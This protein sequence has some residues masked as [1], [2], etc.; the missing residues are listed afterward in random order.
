MAGGLEQDGL[1]GLSQSKPLYDDTKKKKG[2]EREGLF[3]S[4]DFPHGRLTRT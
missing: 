3:K 2:Y 1:E 4:L